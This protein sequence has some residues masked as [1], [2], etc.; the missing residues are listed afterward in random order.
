MAIR[1]VPENK[2]GNSPVRNSEAESIMYQFAKAAVEAGD[3]VSLP[4]DGLRANPE[5]QVPGFHRVNFES[6]EREG[7]NNLIISEMAV[8]EKKDGQVVLTPTE[9]FKRFYIEIS[10]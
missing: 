7:I 1:L 9:N 6:P 8:I 5:L 4:I 2:F 10:K 3:W